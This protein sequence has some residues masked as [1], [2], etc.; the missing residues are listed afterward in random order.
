LPQLPAN[1]NDNLAKLPKVFLLHIS[2]AAGGKLYEQAKAACTDS[3]KLA[4]LGRKFVAAKKCL[5]YRITELAY[6]PTS[7]EPHN[8]DE[9]V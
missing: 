8:L 5:A 1:R 4:A 9:Y 7:V 2:V 6:V 3:R